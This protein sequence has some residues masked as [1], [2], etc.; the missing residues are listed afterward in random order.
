MIHR[1][2]EYSIKCDSCKGMLDDRN[3]YPIKEDTSVNIEIV[4]KSEGW[5]ISLSK[6]ICNKCK[7]K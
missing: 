4:A 7:Q 5:E 2:I 6:H 3:F 1:S